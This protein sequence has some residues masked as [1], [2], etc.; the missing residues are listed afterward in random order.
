[1]RIKIQ[2]VKAWEADNAPIVWGFFG[3]PVG[4]SG[5][6]KEMNSKLNES[7]SNTGEKS[8]KFYF[9][10]IRKIWYTKDKRSV[11]IAREKI[12]KIFANSNISL[13]WNII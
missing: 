9:D 2:R 10:N 1:M 7:S 12:E 4:V 3:V 8:E 5:V 6:F 11:E 13:I